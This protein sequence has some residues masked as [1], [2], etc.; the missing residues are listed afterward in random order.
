[1]AAVLL[2][3]LLH[4][5]AQAQ[6]APRAIWTWEQESY[7]MLEQEAAAE[8]AITFLKAK[9]IRTI[10]LYADAFEGRNLIVSH[11]ELYRAFLRKL[12]KSG[13]Q[14]H[15]LLGSAYLN[16]ERY[17]LPARRADALAM[18]HRVLVYNAASAPEERFEGINLD[19]EPHL[20]DEW[21]KERMVLLKHFLD[22]SADIMDLKRKYKQTL[23][24]G[25]AIPFWWDNIPMV[26]RGKRKHVSEHT[27]DL[28]D[29][30]ALMA[31][32]D[33]AEGG[34]GIIAHA[35][36]ELAYGKA[37]GRSVMVGIETTPNEI[38]KVSF[39]HLKEADMER[40]LGIAERSFRGR[41]A[42]A[43]FVFHHYRGYRRW[44][45]R[46]RR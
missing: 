22:M 25:P 16:T 41:N 8:S 4:G 13:M 33:R 5:L 23:Q 39:D 38:Q 21:D 34:D 3:M 7:A 45:E 40:E 14:A 10:Y 36:K 9:G 11:P 15:A 31:Y 18:V 42:F 32:R 19:I 29:Y 6:Q 2:S 27:Q 44:L 43:G 24:I 35:E 1:M 20:L 28:Y 17:V 26:W 46:P 30:V 12:R 37:I